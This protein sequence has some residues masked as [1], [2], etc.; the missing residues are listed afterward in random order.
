M[1]ST[2]MIENQNHDCITLIMRDIGSPIITCSTSEIKPFYG[3]HF[4]LLLT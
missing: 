4:S 1:F 3:I 2:V